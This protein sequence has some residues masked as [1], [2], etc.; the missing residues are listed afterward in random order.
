MLTPLP[1]ADELGAERSGSRVN[2][3][4]AEFPRL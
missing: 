1:A 3:V 2:Q 4:T